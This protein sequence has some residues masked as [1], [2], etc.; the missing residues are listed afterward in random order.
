MLKLKL[1]FLIFI[2]NFGVFGQTDPL[3]SATNPLPVL[4]QTPAT[5][6][7]CWEVSCTKFNTPYPMQIKIGLF[8]GEISAFNLGAST[9]EIDS[10]AWLKWNMCQRDYTNTTINPSLTLE[11]SNVFGRSSLTTTVT[12]GTPSCTTF[13]GEVYYEFRFEGAFLQLL[14]LKKF[15]LDSHL[16]NIQFEDVYYSREYLVYAGDNVFDKQYTNT[17]GLK[18]G[19]ELSG[20]TITS[21]SQ[22]ESPAYYNSSNFQAAYGQSIYSNYRF[23]IKLSRGA[24]F[25]ILKVLPPVLFTVIISVCVL[26]LDIDSMDV[27]LGTTAGGMLAEI[28]L[29][30][31]FEGN[32][33]NTDYLTL[34]DWVF[35]LTYLAILMIFFECIVLRKLYFER[36]FAEEKLKAQKK[37][38]KLTKNKRK[39]TSSTDALYKATSESEIEISTFSGIT[40]KAIDKANRDIED[41]QNEIELKETKRELEKKMTEKTLLA[42]E[43]KEHEKEEHE[44]KEHEKK[45][46]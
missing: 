35:D 46:T 41:E 27:R 33:P 17:S 19:T 14:S 42:H 2:F 1:I 34:L 9:V 25:Y 23:Q 45:R 24:S 30:L 21:F 15:P 39:Q 43:K 29:Q 16:I 26:L 36:I 7:P 8:L 13:P 3:G 18:D 5:P 31:S 40:K 20:W 44:K 22:L 32:L 10:Y 38:H 37:L 4:V 11:I 6:P 12:P 28:F